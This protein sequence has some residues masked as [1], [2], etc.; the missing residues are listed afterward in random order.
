MNRRPKNVINMWGYR[1]N[2][3]IE[4]YLEAGGPVEEL[5][6]IIRKSWRKELQPGLNEAIEVVRQKHNLPHDKIVTKCIEARLIETGLKG[7]DKE[8]DLPFVRLIMIR[9]MS[10]K[11]AKVLRF[12]LKA[13]KK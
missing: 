12:L 5:E 9:L 7:W 1:L 6:A 11:L 3:N 10:D 4:K 8:K 2:D 13:T